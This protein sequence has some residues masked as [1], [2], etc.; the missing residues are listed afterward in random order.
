MVVINCK[1]TKVVFFLVVISMAI[2]TFSIPLSA[3]T[4]QRMERLLGETALSWALAASFVLEA[5]DHGNFSNTEA[6]SFAF[7]RNWLPKNAVPEEN[8]RLNGISLLLMESFSLKGGIM[9]SLFKNSHFAYRELVYRRIIQGR[10]DPDMHVSGDELLFLTGKFLSIREAEEERAER[11]RLLADEEAQR[12]ARERAEREAM[13]REINI[14]LEAQRVADTTARVTDTGVTISLTN[15]QFLANS[16]ELAESERAK[17]R[18]IARI[19]GTIPDRNILVSGHTALAGTR[20]AQQRTS[21]ERARS[22]AN[23]LISLGARTSAEITVRGYGADQPVADNSTEE[24]MA[25]NRRVEITI[26][27][28]GGR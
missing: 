2:M 22:V 6:F 14:Q 28:T 19:L 3:Q 8:A 23:Y 21:L 7:E 24:G 11:V 27:Q 20:A 12:L 13:A 25:Q 17:L 4:G 9:Y 10:T 15:I 5:A 1:K 26:L 16:A 18:E